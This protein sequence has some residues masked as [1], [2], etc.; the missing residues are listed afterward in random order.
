MSRKVGPSFEN[1]WNNADSNSLLNDSTLNGILI[2]NLLNLVP[3]DEE[4]DNYFHLHVESLAKLD[5]SDQVS[6]EM[7]VQSLQER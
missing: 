3:K 1:D 7:L 5:N 6:P 4:N 2:E